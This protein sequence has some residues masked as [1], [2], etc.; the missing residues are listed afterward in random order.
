MPVNQVHLQELLAYQDLHASWLSLN[1]RLPLTVVKRNLK[2][3]R[4]L[5]GASKIKLEE[6]EQLTQPKHNN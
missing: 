6:L 1:E 5:T 4:G 2:L 3:L